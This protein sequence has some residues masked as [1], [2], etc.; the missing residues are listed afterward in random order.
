MTTYTHTASGPRA[1]LRSHLG[2]YVAG[3]G[4]TAALTAGAL[5]VFLSMSAFVAFNGLPFGESSGGA[6]AAYL[7]PVSTVA[8]TAGAALGTAPDA[9]AKDP[10]RGSVGSGAGSRSAA[11][12]GSGGSRPGGDSTGKAPPGVA[13]DPGTSAPPGNFTPPRIDVPSLPS[14]SG[15]VT[16]AVESVD[17]ALGTNLSRSTGGATRA[18]DG[19]A[20]GALDRVGA[21]ADR[22]GLG[23]QAD[24]V[25]SGVTGALG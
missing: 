23:R 18:G 10:V 11:A 9:V 21:A 22:S 25:V 3:V 24:G 19:A 7:E 6:G 4:A 15:P 14:A 16:S 8:P 5:V 1:H 2:T 17:R 13:T 20:A 12:D